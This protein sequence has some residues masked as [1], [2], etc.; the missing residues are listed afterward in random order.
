[1]DTRVALRTGFAAGEESALEACYAE[2]GPMVLG[3]LRRY[4]PPEE[5]E[6]VLQK[7]LLEAWRAHDRYD[8]ERP[9]EAWLLA[10]ARRRAIDQ[11]RRR[12]AD[13]VSIDDVRELTDDD[14][15]DMADRFAWAAE[16]RAALDTLPEVQR[17]VIELAYFGDLT[18]VQIAE[19]IEVPL[20]TVKARTARGMQRLAALL[21]A[22]GPA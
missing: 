6:D 1:M 3:Y 20:G 22:G 12:R 13:V 17:Q 18:Q 19:R 10:I 8:P 14:G 16:V 2:L 15:R 7:V 4:L 9:L 5:A 11:L 21:E